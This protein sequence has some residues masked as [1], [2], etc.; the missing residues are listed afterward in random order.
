MNDEWWYEVPIVVSW[1]RAG[2]SRGRR[3]T[4]KRHREAV[5]F[6]RKVAIEARPDDWDT[7][8]RCS[9]RVSYSSPDRRLRDCDRVLSLVLDALRGVAYEDD[10]DRYVVMATVVVLE[11]GIGT[12]KV[13]VRREYD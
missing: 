11:P 3:Y 8:L 1:S 7:R 13:E 5:E 9:V 12:T 4:P 2:D 10:S 6:H